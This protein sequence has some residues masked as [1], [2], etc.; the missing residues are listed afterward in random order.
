[1]LWLVRTSIGDEQLQL[2]MPVPGVARGM[3]A[4]C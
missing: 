4:G 1:M 3:H 2:S